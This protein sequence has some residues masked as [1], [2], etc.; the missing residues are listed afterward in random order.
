MVPAPDRMMIQIY[1][2]EAAPDPLTL[3]TTYNRNKTEEKHYV[4]K[5]DV[6]CD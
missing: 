5:C 1:T 4:I 6:K 3:K 2:F